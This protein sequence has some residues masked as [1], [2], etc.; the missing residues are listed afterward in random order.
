[1]AATIES[2]GKG[3]GLMSIQARTRVTIRPFTPEDYPALAAINNAVYTD[4]PT[5]AEEIRYS[6]EHRDPKCH[7]ARFVA[8]HDGTIVGVGACRHYTD[9]FH[10]RKFYLSVEVHPD[11]QGQ[12]IGSA[13][14]DHVLA[15]LE[16][17]APLSVSGQ[18][19]S[20][21]ERSVRF[22]AARG[23]TERMR[24]WESRLDVAAFDPSPYA[25]VQ[26]RLVA[27][28]IVIKTFADL[29]ADPERNRK[30]YELDRELSA[31]VPSPEP[32][33]PVSYEFFLSRVIEDPDLIPEAYF[34][35]LDEATGEYA[36]MS[37]LWHSQ[38][39]DHL[40][41]GLTAVKRSYRRRGIAL[42]LKLRGIA[43]ATAQGR[44]TIK[45]WNE[46]NNRAM[47]AINEALGFVK[48]PAWLDLVNVLRED[49]EAA[50]APAGLG[51]G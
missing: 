17:F 15:S 37:Q 40:Y 5:S 9:M 29:A 3:K 21:W 33:T 19:R 18:I 16:P 49:D 23:F 45:T 12:G 6:D 27:G 8:E 11:W 35:A 24:S 28:G 30:L 2:K 51:E 25:G 14:Y 1:V 38:G 47:L 48:Q 34:V 36:G 41:N 43:F 46:S 20:D 31:D 26:E 13:V 4:Y 39:S 7:A 22:L 10:P 32:H 50:T 44:P 42:A